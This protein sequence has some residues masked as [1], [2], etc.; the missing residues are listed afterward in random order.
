[1][2]TASSIKGKQLPAHSVLIKIYTGF[3]QFLCDS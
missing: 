2:S 3:T 1:M